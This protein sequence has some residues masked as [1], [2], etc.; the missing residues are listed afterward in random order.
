MKKGKG[1]EGCCNC[2][3]NPLHEL[4]L[5]SRPCSFL[6]LIGG[7]GFLGLPRA[8]DSHGLSY[9]WGRCDLPAHQQNSVGA[10]DGPVSSR[11]Q[12]SAGAMSRDRGRYRL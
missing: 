1:G 6:L 5:L 12:A 2:F 7:H 8:A 9:H 10:G 3:P 4:F 11:W